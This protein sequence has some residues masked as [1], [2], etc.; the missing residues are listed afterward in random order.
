MPP[1]QSN[2]SLANSGCISRVL[3]VIVL[4]P[5]S[6]NTTANRVCI[7]TA[8]WHSSIFT[9]FDFYKLKERKRQLA[10]QF[11]EGISS[12]KPRSPPVNEYKDRRVQTAIM[13][14]QIP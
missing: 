4:S 8:E 7:R 9:A 10:K 1:G 14:L 2:G 11:L 5:E 13:R 12:I 3:A 6:A